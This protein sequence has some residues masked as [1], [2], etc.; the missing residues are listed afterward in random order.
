MKWPPDSATRDYLDLFNAVHEGRADDDRVQC[1]DCRKMFEG[2]NISYR[3]RGFSDSLG[4]TDYGAVVM[5]CK[6]G[7]VCLP[8]TLRRCHR[9]ERR[10]K[11]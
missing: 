2:T 9:F 10:R 7:F 6:D 1:R 5:K 8:D 4:V 11:S 3:R